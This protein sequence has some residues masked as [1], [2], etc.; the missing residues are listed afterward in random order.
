[1]TDF[2]PNQDFFPHFALLLGMI[3]MVVVEYVMT[4]KVF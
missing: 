2:S 1:M 3:S 4:D